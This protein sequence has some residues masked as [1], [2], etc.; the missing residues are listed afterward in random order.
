M[1]WNGV[2]AT[3]AELDALGFGHG[4]EDIEADGFSYVVEE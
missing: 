4:A 3:G 1:M 2:R